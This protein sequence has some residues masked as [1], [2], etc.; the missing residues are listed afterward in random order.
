M[1]IV[2][3]RYI[4]S[5]VDEAI[6]FY[7]EQLDFDLVMHPDPVSAILERGDLRLLLSSPDDQEAGGQNMP[8]TMKPKPGDWNRFLLEINE[9]EAAVENLKKEGV[10]FRN[11]IIN[12]TEGKHILLEDPFGNLIELFEY[13]KENPK[14]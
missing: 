3:V 7:T 12:G 9:L 13:Y 14:L 2:S 8:A 1:A 10:H 11:D 5:D 6:H 4:V